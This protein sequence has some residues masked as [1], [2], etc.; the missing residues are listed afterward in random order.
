[1]NIS[2]ADFEDG[3][4]AK[5]LGLA[6]QGTRDNALGVSIF[7]GSL[8]TSIDVMSSDTLESLMYRISEAGYKTA[9]VNDGS[10]ATPYRLTIS[11]SNTGEAS[12]F[13]IESD[14]DDLF[15]F[16]QV[17]RGKDAKVLYGDPAS[18]AS[19]MILS[20][21]TNSNSS[22]IL[23]LTL[24]IKAV[25]DSYTTIS[26]DT[27]KEKVVEEIKNMVQAYNDLNDLVS[28]LDAYDAETNAPG[29]LFGDTSIRQLMEDI[30]DQFYRIFNPDQTTLGAVDENGKL[31]T[32]TWMDM[33]I[34]LSA[35]NSATD[36][37]GTWY[38]SMDLDLDTLDSM[39]ANNWDILAQMLAGQ[40]NASNSKLSSN[41]RA[42]ASFN[43]QAADGFSV[44]NAINGDVN[45]G[46]WGVNNGLLAD[47]TI[48]EGA[49]EYSIYFQKPTTIS[50][51]SVYH[52]DAATALKDYTIEYLD[53]NTG[54][55]ET[56]REVTSN[57]VDSNHFGMAL[58]LTV[59]AVRV[60]ASSTNADDGK[61]RLLDVQIFE[62]IGLAGQLNQLT[63]TLGDSQIGFLA[64]RT[65][66][67]NEKVADLTEQMERL[68][69]KLDLK[70]ESLWRRFN[71]META[72]GQLQSQSSFFTSM[73][74]SMSSSS[75]SGK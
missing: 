65:S 6:G 35:K 53:A 59:N 1:G 32:W 72:L 73:M 49:N 17:S 24:D 51:L 64:E 27:D 2:I 5:K 43:G 39:V 9:I 70:E 12:D 7:E 33:G 75:S 60:T 23:G 45:K 26:V 74:S 20:S 22:A 14:L 10:G 71:A 69:A 50:R 8:R 55:W 62:D 11:S 19:P 18:G 57:S 63:T 56:F 25:S 58:P 61:F 34:T 37:S 4:L 38:S 29:V 16:N 15:G 31:R 44:E 40:R 13:V 68:Q 42:T 66:V 47:K 67:V 46:S 52:N 36:N 28:Y 3:T 48:A 30:N 54:K 21:A 41:S